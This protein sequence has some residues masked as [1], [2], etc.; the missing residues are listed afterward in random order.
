MFYKCP[1]LSTVTMLAPSDQ[2]SK[3]T[4]CCFDWLYNTGTDETVS[5]RTLI[6]TDE[7]AYNALKSKYYLPTKWQIGNCTVLDKDGKAITE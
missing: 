1:K 4:I 3:A 7:A 5:S 6:V 2:I